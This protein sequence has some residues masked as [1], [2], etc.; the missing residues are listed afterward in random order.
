MS[1]LQT[2]Q[3]IGGQQPACLGHF[4]CLTPLCFQVLGAGTL[5]ISD[6][7][8]SLIGTS[9][10]GIIDAI[11]LNQASGVV[12]IWFEGDVYVAGSVQFKAVIYKPNLGNAASGLGKGQGSGS[13]SGGV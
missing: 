1:V 12:T 7:S 10:D 4:K 2:V 11:Q 9:D 5:Y 13:G 8:Q 3:Q 6:N